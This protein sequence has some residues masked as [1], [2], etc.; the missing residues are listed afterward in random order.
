MENVVD[1][2]VR[3]TGKG[4]VHVTGAVK[5]QILRL[6]AEKD[7]N[8]TDIARSTNKAQSTLSVHLDRMMEDGLIDSEQDPRDGRKRIYSLSSVPVIESCPVNRDADAAA[9]KAAESIIDQQ[10]DS[11]QMSILDALVFKME[12]MGITMN[13]LFRI[14]G[15]DAAA[16][17]RARSSD[18]RIE[19]V[20][21]QLRAAVADM[22]VGDVTIY[23]LM[24]VTIIL[25]VPDGT[26]RSVLTAFG[27]FVEGLFSTV[28]SD[29]AGR[30]YAVSSSEIFGAGENYRRFIIESVDR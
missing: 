30:E 28:I 9:R 5:R 1:F 15:V 18:S 6:L 20:L 2:E 11:R 13:P 7:M 3:C 19:D 26:P 21:P 16:A 23:S 29:I 27:M 22:G 10:Q 24:P 8:L 17:V 25:H 14:I 12:S 4:P